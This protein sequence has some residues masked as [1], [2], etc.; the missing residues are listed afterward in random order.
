MRRSR[1]LLR[2]HGSTEPVDRLRL[3]Q[4]GWRT[5]LD[6]R[7]NHCRDLDGILSAVESHWRGEA[8]RVGAG[9]EVVVLAA[10][11]PS[12]VTVWRRLRIEAEVV[13]E[14]RPSSSGARL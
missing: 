14:R 2:R 11:G 4:A 7:E 9:G 12:P 1:G 5:T 3:E 8:E 10:N 13:L 6:Y